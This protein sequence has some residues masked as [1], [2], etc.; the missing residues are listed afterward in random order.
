[1]KGLLDLRFAPWKSLTYFLNKCF[2]NI[3]IPIQ[4][5]CCCCCLPWARL[6]TEKYGM[7]S[8]L[9]ARMKIMA[10]CSMEFMAGKWSAPPVG[11]KCWCGGVRPLR[12]KLLTM[13]THWALHKLTWVPKR[14]KN[15]LAEG[16]TWQNHDSLRDHVAVKLALSWGVLDRT[17]TEIYT[18]SGLSAEM[19]RNH[20]EGWWCSQSK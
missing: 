18:W 2:M 1:M 4:F 8:V 5:C 17:N 19:S 16:S 11:R 3:F 7:V 14:R 6:W 20:W 9:Q 15:I 12:Q 10:E 13:T